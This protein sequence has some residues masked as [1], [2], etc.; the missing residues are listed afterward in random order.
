M[1]ELQ[2][3][4]E[5]AQPERFAAAPLINFRVRAE[6]RDAR[7]RICNVMLQCQIRIEAPL[8]G[9][10]AGEQDKLSDVFG[11][12]DRWSNTLH[13]L[14]WTHSTLI[15]PS[16]ERSCTFLLPAP[17]S[18]DFNVAA[19]K[20]FH[21]LEAGDVPLLLLFSGSIFYDDGGSLQIAQVG[22]TQEASY[23]LPVRVWQDMMSHYYPESSWLRLSHDLLERLRQYK[24]RHGLADWEH[25]L[26]RLLVERQ[27]ET[28]A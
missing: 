26:A 10:G 28:A 25:A 3:T 27:R 17:C 9:Y 22:S 1:L 14:L 19:T 24:Q 7:A 21:G 23:R 6:C 18:F 8:R 16:F 15:V 4:V 20:Y 12:A 11:A 2:F 13:S 5:D